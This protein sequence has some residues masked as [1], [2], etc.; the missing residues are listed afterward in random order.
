MIGLV[1]EYDLD[2]EQVKSHIELSLGL[3]VECKKQ[4]LIL[5]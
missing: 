4:L 5:R 2:F 3:F 1:I